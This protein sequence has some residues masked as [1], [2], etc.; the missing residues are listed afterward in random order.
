[1][2]EL[3]DTYGL[4]P[5]GFGRGGSSPLRPKGYKMSRKVYV[6][7]KGVNYEFEDIDKIYL[8]SYLADKRVEELNK[9]ESR[10]DYV[11]IEEHELID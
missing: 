11:K 1:M 3:A 8:D 10:Y 7:I 2:V 5:Y 9:E 4:S 6:V